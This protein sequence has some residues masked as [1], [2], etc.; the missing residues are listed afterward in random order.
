M[1]QAVVYDSQRKLLLVIG[2]DGN[3]SVAGGQRADVWGLPLAGYS[4]PA[5]SAWLQMPSMPTERAGL[6]GAY[7]PLPSVKNT[8]MQRFVPTAL[9]GQQWKTLHWAKKLMP[10][11]YPFMFLL[12]TGKL[13]WAGPNG[14][15]ACPSCQV[16]DNKTLLLEPD[17][18]ATIRGWLSTTWSNQGYWGGTAAMHYVG[19]DSAKIIKCGVHHEIIGDDSTSTYVISF[20]ANGNTAGWRRVAAPTG[21]LTAR[22]DHN[23]VILPSGSVL[24]SGGRTGQRA[25]VQIWNPATMQWLAELAE[26]PRVRNYHSTAALLPDGRV[27][28]AGGVHP[29]DYQWGTLYEPPHLFKSDGTYAT[30]PVINSAPAS[31]GWGK[32]FTI[33]VPDTTAITRAC[34]IRPANTTHAFDQNQRY[35]PLTFTKVGNPVRLLVQTPANANV[36]PPGY[37]M[38]FLTGSADGADV[39]AIGRWVRLGTPAGRDTCDATD[40][41]T[42]TTLVPEVVSQSSIEFMWTATADDRRLAAS[43]PC[44]EYDFR[45]YISPINEGSWGNA[46]PTPGEPTPGSVGTVQGHTVSNLACCTWYHFAIRALDDNIHVSAIHPQVKVKTLCI[47]CSGLTTGSGRDAEAMRLSIPLGAI[48][49]NPPA[50]QVTGGPISGG[51]VV[52]TRRASNGGWQM[53]VRRVAEVAGLEAAAAGTIVLQDHHQTGGWRTRR[54]LA[55]REGPIGLCAVRDDGRGV[56]FGD[57]V[58][59]QLAPSLAVGSSRLLLATAFHSRIGSLDPAQVPNAVP[60]TLLEGE[61]LTLTYEASALAPE[62]TES[63]YILMR[64]IEGTPALSEPARPETERLP[65][66]FALYPSQPNPSRGSNLIRFDLP[67]GVEV[68]L[69]VLDIQGRRVRTLAKGAMPPGRHALEWDARDDSG[70]PLP[71]GIYLYRLVTTRFKQQKKLILAR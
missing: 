62:P 45:Y 2:G 33:C 36:A 26:E 7:L 42:I 3:G 31:L 49:G 71:A 4:V 55:P 10:L 43:G 44:Q 17:S 58:P 63:W 9:V 11:T 19:G 30:R 21:A 51:L 53:V 61:S 56:L 14:V 29:E 6:A 60:P 13:A 59:E 1:D 54:T 57:W 47:G 8:V 23:L 70:R 50:P 38:L 15:W 28:A 41:D 52:E 68:A 65:Q 5:D 39:P 64:R 12:P 48:A 27:L 16:S 40:P 22:S 35:I 32:V 67:E 34:L 66:R 18:L 69:E 37:Y 20:D 46:W 25:K 24:A